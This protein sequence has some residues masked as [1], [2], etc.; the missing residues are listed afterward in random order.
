MRK[1]RTD[2]DTIQPG[3]KRKVVSITQS[4]RRRSPRRCKNPWLH[5]AAVARVE[6][7]KMGRLMYDDAVAVIEAAVS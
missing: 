5:V 7:A 2:W 3:L 4:A 6:T 1:S